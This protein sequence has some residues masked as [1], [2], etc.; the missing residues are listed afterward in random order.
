MTDTFHSFSLLAQSNLIQKYIY[1][2]CI[3]INAV[4]NVNEVEESFL[5][6]IEL[7]EVNRPIHE[8]AK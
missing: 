3:I 4:E 6:S 2:E 8:I 5:S 1:Q 7:L